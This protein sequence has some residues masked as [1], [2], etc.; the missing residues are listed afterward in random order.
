MQPP[1]PLVWCTPRSVRGKKR[2]EDGSELLL[3]KPLC[4]TCRGAAGVLRARGLCRK[5]TAG[6]RVKGMCA[7]A[8]GPALSESARGCCRMETAR[9]F[10]A[11][12][13]KAYAWSLFSPGKGRPRRQLP[14]ASEARWGWAA[15]LVSSGLSRQGLGFHPQHQRAKSWGMQRNQHKSVGTGEDGCPHRQAGKRSL[16]SESLS[17]AEGS[18]SPVFTVTLLPKELLP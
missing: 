15:A 12:L 8:P 14:E 13:C 1:P 16:N 10:A 5:K 2:R 9:R 17:A 6:D 11:A 18:H 4:R 7:A 3:H